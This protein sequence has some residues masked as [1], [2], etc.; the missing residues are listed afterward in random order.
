LANADGVMDAVIWIGV[1]VK[2]EVLATG[3]FW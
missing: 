3:Q 1:L 2:V